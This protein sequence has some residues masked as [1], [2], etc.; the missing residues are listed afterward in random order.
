MT[1]VN[2][3]KVGGHFNIVINNGR[4]QIQLW[5]YLVGGN[6]MDI[7]GHA[8]PSYATGKSLA[9][10]WGD[11]DGNSGNDQHHVNQLNAQGKLSVL[12]TPRS[13]FKNK[14]PRTDASGQFL[15]AFDME[16][17]A[18]QTHVIPG[19]ML[20]KDVEIPT[21][22]CPSKADIVA[23]ECKGTYGGFLESCGSDICL[24]AKPKLSGIQAHQG[25]VGDLKTQL[26]PQAGETQKTDT[27]M[28]LNEFKESKTLAKTKGGNSW[29]FSSFIKQEGDNL[30]GTIARFGEAS[31]T[32]TADGDIVFTS[33]GASC[34]AKKV[35]GRKWK[36]VIAVSSGTAKEIRIY[37]DGKVACNAAGTNFE[38][39]QNAFQLGSVNDHID[40]KI[41]KPVY[42]ASGVRDN[43]TNLFTEKKPK[44]VGAAL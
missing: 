3:Y 26:L 13:Y 10:A 17:D 39:P 9:G 35:I 28:I 6:N 40:A 37:V 5:G 14:T 43:E 12:G 20:T 22:E 8:S 33:N 19:D 1:G 31:V 44:C 4:G 29:S 32:S 23:K 2:V 34:T 25:Q 30:K 11:W 18:S 27:C 21:K 16:L 7:Y 41:S 38:T 36:S 24:G 42:V 15:L